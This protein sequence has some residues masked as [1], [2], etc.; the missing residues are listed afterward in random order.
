MGRQ[1]ANQMTILERAKH[2]AQE[3]SEPLEI[4]SSRILGHTPY[5]ENDIEII[6]EEDTQSF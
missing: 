4:D 2:A 3:Q 1:R 5:V 6:T